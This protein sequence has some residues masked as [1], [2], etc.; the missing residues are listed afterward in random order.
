M[1][2]NQNAIILTPKT[3]VA[4]DKLKINYTGYLTQTGDNNIYAHL[5]YTDN[6]KNWSD[7]SNI[8]MYRNANNDFEAIVSVKDKQ[9]LN[10]S[11]YDANGN[12]D[13]NYQNNYS[14]NIKTRP[15]W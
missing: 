15:D 12:W 2:I 14:F 11:F 13:N 7:V 6:T 5:G 8:Q 4:G 9:C 3:P 1:D 10:F